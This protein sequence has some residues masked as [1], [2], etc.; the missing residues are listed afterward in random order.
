MFLEILIVLR[1]S[2]FFIII[3]QSV[4]FYVICD[5]ITIQTARECDHVMC[6]VPAWQPETTSK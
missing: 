3:I 6:V 1:N 5:S 4:S 2:M